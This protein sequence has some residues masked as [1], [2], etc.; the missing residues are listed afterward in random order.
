DEVLVVRRGGV[1]GPHHGAP[2]LGSGPGRGFAPS[3]ELSFPFSRFVIEM[4]RASGRKADRSV[5]FA[6]VTPGRTRSP[7]GR[8]GLLI[9]NFDG[10]VALRLRCQPDPLLP[11]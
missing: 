1:R 7:A 4:Q 8:R 5:G 10:D 6:P 9:G 2:A 3:T 11:P